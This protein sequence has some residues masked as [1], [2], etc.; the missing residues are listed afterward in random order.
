MNNHH[1]WKSFSFL[2]PPLTLLG[3]TSATLLLSLSN[4]GAGQLSFDPEDAGR[5]ITPND[6]FQ[7][8]LGS[9]GVRITPT[10][11]VGVPDIVTL[12]DAS[13][14]GGEDSDLEKPYALGNAIG[15][16]GGTDLTD[17]VQALLI[18]QEHATPAEIAAGQLSLQRGLS[19]PRFP[20][21]GSST[22]GTLNA[23]DDGG[24]GGFI[25]L[26][27][28]EPLATFQ[29][30]IPDLEE[31]GDDNGTP[32]NFAD[33]SGARIAFRDLNPDGS[34]AEE[35]V[36]FLTESVN[37][38]GFGNIALGNNS[39]NITPNFEA[40]VGA[41]S[42]LSD[43]DEID[44]RFG[45]NSGGIAYID[46][47]FAN[48]EANH[49]LGSTVF[50]DN[51]GNGIL[52][53]GDDRIQGVEVRLVDDSP[54]GNI[55]AR[56]TTDSSG[57]YLFTELREG[58]YR[59]EIAADQFA[60]AG[61][62][63][64]A[65]PLFGKTSIPGTVDADNNIDNNDDG[66]PFNGGVRS[67]II[68][69]SPGDELTD[70]NGESAADGGNTDNAALGGDDNGNMTVDFGFID[71][72]AS[73]GDL[74]FLDADGDGIQDPGETGVSGVLFQ[75][76]D[77]N[78]DP[79]LNGAGEPFQ[80]ISAPDG[81][82][83][84]EGVPTGVDY[85]VKVT[86]NNPTLVLTD[87]GEGT[88]SELDSSYDGVGT[89]MGVLTEIIN[90][91]AG[92]NDSSLDAGFVSSPPLVAIFDYGDAP[93]PYPTT[94]G[95]AARHGIINALTIGS[96]V[97]DETDGAPS[98]D[99]SG[100]DLAGNDDE[101]GV[102]FPD[103]AVITPGS[104]S[105]TA[106]VV[107]NG[108]GNGSSSAL[109]ATDDFGSDADEVKSYATGSGW[110]SDWN[111]VA[112]NGDPATGAIA[113]LDTNDA[114]DLP[115]TTLENFPLASK[116]VCL[117]GNEEIERSFDFSSATGDVFLNFA[118]HLVDVEGADGDEFLVLLRSADGTVTE[119]ANI[120]SGDATDNEFT[121]SGSIS[122][123]NALIAG[124]ESELIFRLIGN[125]DISSDAV[126]IDDVTLTG[127]AQGEAKLVAWID[128][129]GNEVFDADEAQVIESANLV[130]DGIS[131]NCVEWPVNAA[132]LD[133]N[134]GVT[135]AR[136]RLS[137][138]PDLD[139]S[140]PGG[141]VDDGEV[142]D[143]QVFIGQT[144]S[145]GNRVFRDL[146]D[147]G[148]QNNGEV[149]IA[150]IRVELF[151]AADTA[152]TNPLQVDFTEGSDGSLGRYFFD[153]LDPALDYVVRV[154]PTASD[155]L[156]SSVTFP[157][158][159]TD[160][161]AN[162]NGSQT[163]PGEPSTSG[164]IS[165]NPG[166]SDTQKDF[167]LLPGATVGDF[168]FL[169]NDNNGTDNGADT[170]LPGVTVQLFAPDDTDFS[171]P[172]DTQVT[173]GNGAYLFENVRPGN[174]V[175]KFTA[176]AGSTVV[177]G[178][179][180]SDNPATRITGMPTMSTGSSFPVAAGAEIDDQDAAFTP[181]VSLGNLVF[182]DENDDGILNNSDAPID[183][184]TVELLAA[185]GTT[186]LETQVTGADG[187]PDG[188]YL[189]E[190]LTP[191]DTYIVRV[192]PNA[193]APVA[194]SSNPGANNQNSGSQNNPGEPSESDPITL[195]SGS[196]LTVDFGFTQEGSASIG[197][198][199]FIDLDGDGVQDADEPGLAGVIFQVFDSNGDPAGSAT[200]DSEGRWFVGGLSPGSYTVTATAPSGSDY[201][202]TAQNQGGDPALDSSYP[203]GG[204]SGTTASFT[205]ANGETNPT[206]DAGFVL[207][208]PG[209]DFGDA[210][211][212]Y[213]TNLASNGPRHQLG[214]GIKFGDSVDAES[215]GQPSANA[216]DD[217]ADEDGITFPDGTT[218]LRGNVSPAP[219]VAKAVVMPADAGQTLRATDNFDTPDG[220]NLS[221]GLGA[222]WLGPWT[223][224][225]GTSDPSTGNVQI[226]IPGS[227]G[228]VVDSSGNVLNP[229]SEYALC[230]RNGPTTISREFD[231]SDAVADGTLTFNYRRLG[232]EGV[233]SFTFRVENIA[234]PAIFDDVVVINGESTEA[235]D[236]LDYG[237]VS[238]SA[239]DV[240]VLQA[241][242]ARLVISASSG[243]AGSDGLCINELTLTAPT[244]LAA[245]SVVAWIDFDR[246][247]VF[248]ADEATI[249]PGSTLVDDGSTENMVMWNDVNALLGATNGTTFARFRV[250]S[251]PALTASTPGGLVG[252]GEV[253]DYQLTITAPSSIGN[254]VF[255]DADGDGLYEPTE[256]D[257]PIGGVTVELLDADGDVIA[258]Q[259][260]NATTGEYLFPNLTGGE[261]YQVRVTPPANAPG[262]S[263]NSPGG[264]NQNSGSQ[265]A[266]GQP[267]LSA[268]ILLPA[269]TDDLTVDFGFQPLFAVG[270]L[271]F[272]DDNDDGIFDS[273]DDTALN[274]VTLT[275]F[276]AD[277]L[278]TPIDVTTTATIDG[279][280]G[281]YLFSGLSAG[282]YVIRVDAGNFTG[283]G[284]LQ[285]AGGQPLNAT[286]INDGDT[287]TDDNLGQN[288][289]VSSAPASI[290]VFSDKIVLGP[291]A[292]E[293]T[294]GETGVDGDS[295]DANSDTTTDLT[296]DFGFRDFEADPQ[297]CF[298]ISG[299]G[300][301]V[302]GGGIS[303]QQTADAMGG[304]VTNAP[305]SDGPGGV[306]DSQNI[307]V[308]ADGSDG[309]YAWS[310]VGLE[311]EFC[312]TYQIPPG[313]IIDPAFT[314]ETGSL[315]PNP[316]AAVNGEQIVGQLDLNDD[317]ILDANSGP[318]N[319]PSGS[320]ASNP[321]YV[322]FNLEDG[323]PFLTGINIPLVKANSFSAW[324]ANQGSSFPAPGTPQAGPL[325]N[326]DNDGFSN[327]L[328][329]ALCLKPTSGLKVF[330]DGSGQNGGFQVVE[331]PVQTA[332]ANTP[333]DPS[334]D[335]FANTEE[336][337]TLNACYFAPGASADLAYELQAY[338]PDAAGTGA[339]PFWSD[340]TVP[341]ANIATSDGPAGSTKVTITDLEAV[342]G[343]ASTSTDHSAIL[344]LSITLDDG[345]NPAVMDVSKVQG[346]TRRLVDPV[347]ETVSDPYG[348]L[349][350]FTGTISGA[351]GFTL[352]F[353]DSLGGDSLGDVLTR[354]LLTAN[355]NPRYYI[356]VVSDPG[357][358]TDREGEQLDIVSFTDST[359]T[360]ANDT[361]LYNGPFNSTHLGSI[362]ADFNGSLVVIREH[363][364]LT[365]IVPLSAFNFGTGVDNS[366]QILLLD[367]SAADP[368]VTRLQLNI[369]GI[370]D[371]QPVLEWRDGTINLNDRVVP[372]AEGLY[373]HHRGRGGLGS[374]ELVQAGEVRTNAVNVPLREGDNLIGSLYPVDQSPRSRNILSTNGFRGSF[375]P[376][377]SDLI[378]NW[379]ADDTDA[380][381]N[382]EFEEIFAFDTSFLLL[383]GPRNQWNSP[384]GGA[385]SRTDDALFEKDRS[386][387]IEI[388]NLNATDE[389]RPDFK[390]P[391]QISE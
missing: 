147:D 96:S 217:G 220:S 1:S 80:A 335:V 384:T 204:A 87:E 107:V 315:D 40:G 76:I 310:V 296:I 53:A 162:N 268:L 4:A 2:R 259:L 86:S 11:N 74:A 262:A 371:N 227:S 64:P 337:T 32:N 151:D 279:Q 299:T 31:A 251:D 331:V 69:L 132:L 273:G 213:Q 303:V 178:N 3:S 103:G 52:D 287:G 127:T 125:V 242:P 47:T 109:S 59:I 205:L 56:T 377:A 351:S 42:A 263:N 292:V 108:A 91:S 374:F 318:V 73:I 81:S 206:L 231:F 314:F 300:E 172:I 223:D 130:S 92:E 240:A 68:N 55:I 146:N 236:P 255:F 241:G 290:G 216:S 165:L 264:D 179:S 269:A 214:S 154:Y 239:I 378:K 44:V 379:V 135:F 243:N 210:P 148:I 9:I 17:Q 39:L 48:V 70:A 326:P 49:S 222:G 276:D 18:L 209:L 229:E 124:G 14:T 202:L 359:V 121:P 233:D 284:L 364:V 249:V 88:D 15:N 245:P 118:Y 327:L 228:F 170:G 100:D 348:K 28:E 197:D 226:A 235:N 358:D 193:S 27:F 75:L 182:F 286:V 324:A 114:P 152:F 198:L 244:A 224:S 129:D 79:V 187:R 153:N 289:R 333:N 365:D 301:I 25:L 111:E 380:D 43:I 350:L 355:G 158:D 105:F 35:A 218:I 332:G 319:G 207:P 283:S 140:L 308:T 352:D 363:K 311:G 357:T 194:S 260:T 77:L 339:D 180:G 184:L 246:N 67:P 190:G 45:S 112:D 356:E 349:C 277:D 126:C 163:A 317:G 144:A 189:F 281:R 82:W 22:P 50:C 199:A 51:N 84:I 16:G 161:N 7:R 304:S 191:G 54:S 133:G 13:V 253:E 257:S 101:D 250:S 136:F 361:D 145:L 293:P 167:G 66:I 307:I 97:D 389:S 156:A 367:Q 78:G 266:S 168:V 360:I 278:G 122:I 288:G 353:T 280:Q 93:A 139:A 169:D 295:D 252:D 65:G 181:G 285:Q 275:I 234:N 375:A 386:T 354:S 341:A 340:V 177:A 99:A 72:G 164:V 10:G 83:S 30:L 321:S 298:Y 336:G 200:S 21:G 261:T 256:G 325:G 117:L 203:A 305:V 323:D 330:P 254:L 46:T 329:Y 225:D 131:A 221:Y 95:L 183:G 368:D 369:V 343:I 128:F 171:D 388:G 71:N 247:G 346:F 62:G 344:R 196:D 248:D 61:G 159:G 24:N 215:N 232:L 265:S 143:Y 347:C 98:G 85:R 115:Q 383:A 338:N 123:P 309:C 110:T 90:L 282:C 26:R 150:G 116:A 33:D 134:S 212:S 113:I 342:L 237:L 373:H 192:T 106:K 322:K 302:P 186:V 291:G 366:S 138:D 120:G 29:T 188:Q 391:S 23:P 219:F 312:V 34:L 173:D 306:I 137:S 141:L 313:Y 58:D 195:N 272:L 297:G 38:P 89:N 19:S 271:V 381:V 372:P 160:T 238:I 36:V 328:E 320:L 211:N 94:G 157:T 119:I 345:V 387:I 41:L 176:P 8:Y 316:S 20:L 142:E 208:D 294:S 274:G 267:S 270:N 37:V 60:P 149:G 12:Y 382:G 63:N 166:Q 104:T 390:I 6:G 385:V 5:L 230:L 334:D 155:P 102:T 201:T 376:S 185:N 174:Y 370:V 362:G 57:N 258:T 175:V